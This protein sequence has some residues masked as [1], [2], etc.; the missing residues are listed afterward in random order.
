M[1]PA[2]ANASDRSETT[3]GRLA[4]EIRAAVLTT[5]ASDTGKKFLPNAA[6]LEILNDESLLNLFAE[7]CAKRVLQPQNDAAGERADSVVGHDTPKKLVT[8]VRSAP[9]RVCLLAL[10][11]Y[12]ERGRCLDLL[13][14]W[15]SAPPS[16][17]FPSDEDLP[18]DRERAQQVFNEKDVEHVLDYQ[19]NFVPFII[20][21]NDHHNLNVK[22]SRFPFRGEKTKLGEGISGVVYKVTIAAGHYEY[23]RHNGYRL[24]DEDYAVAMK[25]FH[26]TSDDPAESARED[27]DVEKE[28]LEQ[29]KREKKLH[30]MIL[31]HLGSIDE[32]DGARVLSRSLFFELAL[33][34]LDQFF[35]SEQYKQQYEDKGSVLIAKAIDLLDALDFLHKTFQ[36]LHMDL[37]PDN[38]LVFNNSERE[39]DINWKLSD[40]SLSQKK[41]IRSPV[42]SYALSN[43]GSK[44]STIIAARDASLYQ[45]PEIQTGGVSSASEGSD[46]WSMGCLILTLLAFIRLDGIEQ[47]QTLERVLHVY[48]IDSKLDR[49]LF[50]VTNGMRQW[51]NQTCES[52]ELDLKIEKA[53]IQGNVEAML[54]PEL[55]AWI[56][57][58]HST[59]VTDAEQK[60]FGLAAK[61]ILQ[62]VLV[63]DRRKRASASDFRDRLQEVHDIYESLHTTRP[64]PANGTR[65]KPPSVHSR[66]CDAIR[67]SDVEA[68]SELIQ[69]PGVSSQECSH[70]ACNEYP[71]HQVLRN[72]N[73]PALEE[74]LE[75]LEADDFKRPSRIT[76]QTPLDIACEDDGEEEVLRLMFS[77][78]GET[79]DISKEFLNDVK[80]TGAARRVLENWR[81][82][83]KN[84]LGRV[85]TGSTGR[86]TRTLG[87][88]FR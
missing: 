31:L 82:K 14:N 52:L 59:Q 35:K 13:M 1:E 24:E 69:T 78:F 40:F 2:L 65:R 50:Y 45:A 75:S 39:N 27:Y 22:R 46:I 79:V 56:D 77:R 57:H 4:K 60:G 66:L 55:I 18:F 85:S 30:K 67:H 72:N 43:A 3:L 54:H 64:L 21:E 53:S 58:L 73:F 63:I 36:S 9:S 68:I 88:F 28:F 10:F 16:A 37:K 5:H 41:L 48:T 25:V 51:R 71:L 70:P 17:N 84:R 42:G 49:R 33:C 20:R 38:I 87:R 29:L 74:V 80:C 7:L 11:L 12:D 6:L 34:N 8:K 44:R 47:V 81:K 61:I 83:T 26:A 15:L 32:V 86:S 19:A 62:H 23:A 76:R